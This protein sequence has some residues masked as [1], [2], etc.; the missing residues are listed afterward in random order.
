MK[1]IRRKKLRSGCGLLFRQIMDTGVSGRI[2]EGISSG[3][4]PAGI[5]GRN[6]GAVGRNYRFSLFAS[7]FRRQCIP[8][9]GGLDG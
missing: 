7:V 6:V 4:D 5:Y 2:Y 8:G 3:I 9:T 1:Q